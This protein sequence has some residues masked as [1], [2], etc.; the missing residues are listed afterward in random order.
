[1]TKKVSLLVC[2]LWCLSLGCVA[3]TPKTANE[4]VDFFNNAQGECVDELIELDGDLDFSGVGGFPMGKNG[5]ENKPFCGTFDGHGFSIKNLVIEEQE[6]SGL[7]YE[8]L[9]GTVQNVVIDESCNMTGVNVGVL[10]I[11]IRGKSTVVNVTSR[12]KVNAMTRAGFILFSDETEIGS[13]IRFDHCEFGGDVDQVFIEQAG[14]DS[15]QGGFTLLD[16]CQNVNITFTNCVNN[17]NMVA[18]LGLGIV[19]AGGF[20]ISVELSKNVNIRIENC[21]NNGVWEFTSTNSFYSGGCIGAF[22]SVKNLTVTVTNFVNNG[23]VS[24]QIMSGR[25]G[26]LG[27]VIGGIRRNEEVTLS[28]SQSTC[29]GQLSITSDSRVYTGGFIGSVQQNTMNITLV[30]NT[31]KG[32]V[33]NHFEE[34]STFMS[35]GFVGVLTADVMTHV[36]IGGCENSG[37]VSVVDGV[38]SSSWLGGFIGIL[39]SMKSDAVLTLEIED[40]VNR[41]DI[42]SPKQSMSCGMF[43]AETSYG[44]ITSRVKNSVNKGRLNGEKVYGIAN[45]GTWADNVVNMG[46]TNGMTEE[47]H[48]FGTIGELKN[49]YGR[50][51]TCNT[52]KDQ[53]TVTLFEKNGDGVYET[54][55]GKER[56][57]KKLNGVVENE[58]YGK[59]WTSGLEL[60][61]D[62]VEVTLSGQVS[63]VW[64]SGK[65]SR[66]GDIDILS[67]VMDGRHRFEEVGTSRKL[68]RK[69]VMERD[70][71]IRVTDKDRVLIE[72]D[73]RERWCIDHDDV[74]RKVGQL[75]KSEETYVVEEK[76]DESGRIVGLVVYVD[77]GE[78]VIGALNSVDKG[79]GCTL[80]LI[81]EVTQ[82]CVYTGNDTCGTSG[83]VVH[84]VSLMFVVF[85]AFFSLFF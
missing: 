18:K 78:K 58:G 61:E 15:F 76:R 45:V 48:L 21:T 3:F 24:T 70:I 32:S 67:G 77:E 74:G 79:N 50:N 36:V 13:E 51:K 31:N 34:G 83:G 29:N 23:S 38:R 20:I 10:A 80:G 84:V 4:L 19:N 11:N 22:A 43:C 35:G 52:C 49:G 81:C 25:E 42:R 5:N 66:L 53:G 68:G 30:N 39:V 8:I 16:S 65:G 33:T 47:W 28:I 64:T 62:C 56:V 6:S 9:N 40:S 12:C 63:G 1:M 60:S 26:D 2:V 37:E 14:S 41:G 54:L 7:F 73:K 44:P 46:M 69:T 75:M 82:A 59:K 72:L 27:G 85:C 17:A 71:E 57:E 55:E